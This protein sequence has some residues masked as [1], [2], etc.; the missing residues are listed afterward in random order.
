V[1]G[2]SVAP[3]PQQ[4]M[5]ERSASTAPPNTPPSPALPSSA[6]P[7]N[8]PRPS[9]PSSAPP[10]SVQPASVQPPRVP[11]SSVPPL[12]P[13]TSS[14]APPEALPS[15]LAP[16]G[17]LP[18]A[19]APAT[20]N[21]EPPVRSPF[22]ESVPPDAWKEHAAEGTTELPKRRM[23]AAADAADGS[24]GASIVDPPTRPLSLPPADEDSLATFDRRVILGSTPPAIEDAEQTG[25]DVDSALWDMSLLGVDPEPT[26]TMD[27]ID[28]PRAR[29]QAGSLLAQLRSKGALEP[30]PSGGDRTV[31]RAIPMALLDASTTDSD[32]TAVGPAPTAPAGRDALERYYEQVF[33]EFLQVK[34][35]CGEPTGGIEYRGFR[36]KLVRTRGSLMDRFNCVDVRFRVYVKDGRAALKAAPILDENA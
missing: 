22:S 23:G 31:V 6:P 36:T 18:S 9:A 33:E 21:L 10:A 7:L 11:P 3:A 25:D 14:L 27:S 2:V 17:A 32:R 35:T 12:N 19:R 20:V 26:A 1:P 15:G 30:Q 4:V 16:V 24:R 34:R 5:S 13:P 29:K 8:A 28:L